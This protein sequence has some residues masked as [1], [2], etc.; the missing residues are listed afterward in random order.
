MSED[1]D[2]DNHNDGDNNNNDDNNNAETGSIGSTDTQEDP[3]PRLALRELIAAF[4]CLP[5]E[6]DNTDSNDGDNRNN[7]NKSNNDDNTE[8]GTIRSTESF[9]TMTDITNDY[10]CLIEINRLVNAEQAKVYSGKKKNYAD[11]VKFREVLG[12]ALSTQPC[13]GR[14]GGYSW[15]V[16]K[17]RRR[18]HLQG[19]GNNTIYSPVHAQRTTIANRIPK[20]LINQRIQTIHNRPTKV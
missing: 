13:S 8:T 14:H 9:D 18:L 7:D 17:H 6:D 11:I 16:D 1:N 10:R 20:I 12:S 15:L 4:S 3:T 19:W 2:S 5:P